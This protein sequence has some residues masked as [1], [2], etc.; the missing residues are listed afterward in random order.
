MDSPRLPIIFRRNIFAIWLLVVLLAACAPARQ[1]SAAPASGPGSGPAQRGALPGSGGV[2]SPAQRDKPYLILVSL[3]GFKAEYL[4]RFELPNLRRLAGR[5]AR[6]KAMV[7]VFPTLTFP[8]H[9]SLVTGLDP[10]RHG[11]VNNRFFD[12]ARKDTYVYTEPRTVTD[13]SWYGGEPIWVTAESQ[14]MVAACYF[15]PGSEAAIKGIRPTTFNAYTSGITNEARVKTVLAWLDEPIERRPHMITLYFSELDETSHDHP[16]DSPEVIKA[17]QSLDGAI[18]QLADGID[19]L[20]I[21]DQVYIVVTSDHGMV[22]TSAPRT[23]RLESILDPTDASSIT[24]GFSGPVASIH[25]SGGIERARAIRDRINARVARGTAY[26]RQDLPE[27]FKY[28]DNPRSGD[29]VVVMDEGWTMSASRAA[30]RSAADPAPSAIQPPAPAATTATPVRAPGEQRGAHG[31]DNAFPSMRALFL[32]AGPGVREGVLIEEVR[33]VDVYPLLA[34][35]LQL[36][37][38]SGID[39]EAGRIRKLISK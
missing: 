22:N 28:R 9:Y 15:W 13:G 10:Q 38:A 8:N 11:I 16:V 23:V 24:A 30:A 19:R 27:R 29:I 3:D 20:Q 34:E 32:V 26:L 31:W 6:A 35:L 7:P 5:G 18:G 12:P 36:R 21:R 33:K 2:N 14:G 39:G 1:Q 17:A 4:D 25:I 37:P